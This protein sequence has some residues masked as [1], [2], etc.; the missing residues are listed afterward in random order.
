[1]EEDEQNSDSQFQ[2]DMPPGSEDEVRQVQPE[3]EPQAQ[4]QNTSAASPGLPPSTGNARRGEFVLGLGIGAIPL[5]LFFIGFVPT[6][7]VLIVI[8][9]ILWL[10]TL[11]VSLVFLFFPRVR[12]VGYGLL[13]AWAVSLVVGSIGCTVIISRPFG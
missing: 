13:T 3:P 10:V 11:I 1:M 8:G 5:V 4:P 2:P 9:L 7:Y 12:F 6:A